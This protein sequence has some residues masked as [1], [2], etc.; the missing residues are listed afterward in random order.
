M[1]EP[2][3]VYYI[4]TDEFLRSKAIVTEN[5]GFKVFNTEAFAVLRDCN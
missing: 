2:E 5:I 4:G 3:D 1:I